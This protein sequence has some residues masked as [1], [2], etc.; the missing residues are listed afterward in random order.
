MT[1]A[2]LLLLVTNG[3][4]FGTLFVATFFLQDVLGLD[5]LTTGL[6]VLPMTALMVLGAPVAG[7]ALRRYGPRRTALTG[8]VLVVLGIAAL[9]R[10]TTAATAAG[11]GTAFA[12]LGAG[13]TAV[14]VTA[15]TTVIGH[16]PPGY[17]GVAGGL[18][19][20]AMNVGPALGIAVAAGLPPRTSVGPTLLVLAGVAALGPAPA[21][22]LPLTGPSAPPTTGRRPEPA[23]S[24]SGP[25][26][27]RATGT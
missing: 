17:A 16:A 24:P 6:R 11:I 13:F 9:S 3:A 23:S 4:L 20:T 25:A 5:P 12:V 7:A 14:M 15:T 19:Q 21:R 8:S 27:G 18:K 22:R 26:A 10:L 1:A 2:T